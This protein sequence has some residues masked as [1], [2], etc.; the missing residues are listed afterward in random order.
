MKEKQTVLVTGSSRGIGKAIAKRFLQDA[1]HFQ[2]IINGKNKEALDNTLNELLCVQNSASLFAMQ[3]DLSSYEQ[4]EALFRRIQDSLGSVE[5]LINNAGISYLGLFHE[6][7]P[8]DWEKLIQTNLYSVFN[9]CHLATPDMIRKQSGQ[10]INISSIWGEDGA[11][12][13]AVYSASK[14]A[15]N[16]F[17]Q[18]LAKELAPSQIRVNAVSCGVIETGMNAFLSSEEKAALEESIPL[19]NFGTPEQIADLVFFLASEQASYITGQ[20]IRA[21]GGL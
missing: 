1:E 8:Q 2:V 20:I 15:M 16:A 5:I 12:C 4:S 18:A 13:E 10:I 3:A 6:M 11:S 17:T 14:G 19:G 7:K 21:S 9:C